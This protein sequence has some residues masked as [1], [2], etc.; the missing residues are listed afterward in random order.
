[1]TQGCQFGLHNFGHMQLFPCSLEFKWP[2]CLQKPLKRPCGIPQLMNANFP[3]TASSKEI[4]SSLCHNQLFCLCWSVSPPPTLMLIP[5]GTR[6][7]QLMGT[8]DLQPPFSLTAPPVYF[9]FKYLHN[10]AL[11]PSNIRLAGKLPLHSNPLLMASASSDDSRVSSKGRAA[12][13]GERCRATSYPADEL[14]AYEAIKCAAPQPGLS[15]SGGLFPWLR[16]SF[17]V[18]SSLHEQIRLLKGTE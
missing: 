5:L 1:M 8:N 2:T 9:H 3:C 6:Q 14:L 11:K 17:R 18:N 16:V 4:G 15:S 7:L 13:G 12:Q 10:Q